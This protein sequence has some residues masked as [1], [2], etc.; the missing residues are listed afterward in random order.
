MAGQSFLRRKGDITGESVYSTIQRNS[1]YV[2]TTRSS[3]YKTRRPEHPH[4]PIPQYE[5]CPQGPPFTALLQGPEMLGIYNANKNMD[6]LPGIKIEIDNNNEYS[7]TY[8]IYDYSVLPCCNL[9]VQ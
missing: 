8:V 4:S 9:Y 6:T 2:H 3:I 1:T 7:I 5:G